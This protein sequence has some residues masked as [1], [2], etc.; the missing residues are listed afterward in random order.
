MRH[1]RR[2]DSQTS[3]SE[4]RPE[5]VESR[6]ALVERLFREHNEALLRFLVAKLQSSQEAKD[7]AQEAYVR[8]LKLDVPDA[9]SYLR[10]FLFKTASNLAIDRLRSRKSETRRLEMEFFEE[11]LTEPN[12]EHGFLAAEDLQL[13]E[14]SL[15]RLPAKCRQ[16]FLLRRLDGL[17]CAEI[18]RRMRIPERT[19]RHYIVE[20]IVYCRSRLERGADSKGS[21]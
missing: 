18:A 9:V 15:A 21:R 12:P 7:I 5:A 19:V 4:R 16:A 17:S 2:N 6:A 3:A 11:P 20:A 1:F 14:R 10:A 8:L 13:I